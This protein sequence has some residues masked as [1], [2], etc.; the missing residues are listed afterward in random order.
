MFDI[1][2]NLMV[3]AVKGQSSSVHNPPKGYLDGT[4]LRAVV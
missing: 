2:C 1:Y 3:F 4:D